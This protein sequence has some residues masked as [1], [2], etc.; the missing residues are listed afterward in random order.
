MKGRAKAPVDAAVSRRDFLHLGTALAGIAAFSG[1]AVALSRRAVA[2]TTT[3]PG[4]RWYPVM[5][6]YKGATRG[7]RSNRTLLQDQYDFWVGASR[8]NR[9]L[10]LGDGD[11]E[12]YWF[13][14]GQK[15][16]WRDCLVDENLAP[17]SHTQARDP[18]WSNYRWNQQDMFTEMLG[19]SSAASQKKARVRARRK[20][21]GER[22][23]SWEEF[24][25]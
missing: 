24:D 14:G 25:T 22:F 21:K 11:A 3:F 12:R 17:T 5:G 20:A 13:A 18:D 2:D 10:D 19:G 23:V 1:P 16:K 7:W 6:V 9:Y 8:E 4:I 15:M